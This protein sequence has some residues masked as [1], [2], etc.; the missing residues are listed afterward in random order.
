MKINLDTNYLI[1][2]VLRWAGGK[3]WFVKRIEEFLPVKIDDYYEPFAGGLSVLFY[4]LSNKRISGKAYV[5][6]LNSELINF[7]N[8]LKSNPIKLIQNLRKLEN[9]EEFYYEERFRKRYAK[10]TRAAKFYYLNRTSFNG[11][12]RVNQKGQYNVPY[13]YKTYKKFIDPKALLLASELIQEVIF[14]V[15]DFEENAK[16]CNQGD[17]VFFDPPYTVAHENNGFV[18]YNQTIFSWEDQIRLKNKVTQLDLLG[19]KFLVTNAKHKSIDLLYD[20]L[21]KKIYLS[22]ASVI[23]GKKTERQKFNETVIYN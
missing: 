20:N 3:Q 4:L 5:S 6:D 14:S 22:R 1:K 21:G 13:G 18:K 7:Y 12:Y 19:V 23:A 15:C 9:T 2:P 11:I 10:S 8:E 16:D 17:F